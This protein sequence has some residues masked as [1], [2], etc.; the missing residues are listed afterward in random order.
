MRYLTVLAAAL[1]AAAPLAAQT[2]RP[3]RPAEFRIRYDRANAVD[4]LLSFVT[5]SP[6]WHV[7]SGRYAAILYNPAQAAAGRFRA[8]ATIH[9]FPR[10]GHAEGVGLIVGG[11]DLEGPLQRYVYFLIRRDGQ[12]LIK[13]RSGDQTSDVA[14]WT[15]HTA[16]VPQPATDSTGA[17]VRNVLAV[18]VGDQDVAFFV[19][20]QRVHAMP[21]AGA[22]LDGIVGLRVNHYLNIHVQTLTVTPR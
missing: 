11:Q 22:S 7:T 2:A 15:A 3:G 10:E 20:G 4:S 13:R 18:E 8:E 9:L 17:S 1:A 6:G 19:N 12:F 14:P 16:I 21:R 5:M